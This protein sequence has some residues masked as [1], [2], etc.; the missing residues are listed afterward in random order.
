VAVAIGVTLQLGLPNLFAALGLASVAGVRT[1]RPVRLRPGRLGDI[2][3]LATETGITVAAIVWTGGWVSPYLF[4]LAVTAVAVGYTYDLVVTLC[5][6]LGLVL[7]ITGM[8]GVVGTNAQASDAVVGASQVV[9]LFALAGYARR[10]FRVEEA[11]VSLALDRVTR[12]TEANDLLFELHRVAQTLPVTLELGDTLALTG[13]R[14]K[15]LFRADVFAILLWEESTASWQ[16]ASAEGARVASRYT[17]PELPAPVR[18]ALAV[19]TPHLVADLG[20]SGGL[21][22][23]STSGLYVAMRA[24]GSLVG[25]IVVEHRGKVTFTE[26]DARLLEGIGEQAALAID[27][28]RL[29]ERLR[30]VGAHEE[31]S[32]IARDL[33]D[34]VGQSLAYISFELDRLAGRAE[35][36]ELATPLAGL[37]GDVRRA[38]SEVR[39]TL[40][41]LRSEVSEQRGIADVLEELVDR[42]RRRSGLEVSVDVTGTTRLPVPLEREL[43]RIAH[44]AMVN[45]ERHAS[46]TRMGITLQ[47]AAD[48]A[49]LTI[50]DDGVGFERSTGGRVDSFGLLGM[51]ERASAIGASLEISSSPGRG[52][53][54]RCRVRQPEEEGTRA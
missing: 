42:V 49:R 44:E 2:A 39:E 18:A 53:S 36:T 15:E 7:V 26:L 17:E 51:E 27:N 14:V 34:R 40:Y 10:I 13:D 4:C 48:E 6:G 29:F 41:D 16:T 46:A 37:R 50:D 52:T 3:L 28:A 22:P 45:V 54:V 19:G 21:S 30:V 47:L 24:R 31:R 5:A 23:T 8:G 11:R 43:L 1:V 33:H 32:R 38:V 35:G 9:L 25:L 20:A 12:L